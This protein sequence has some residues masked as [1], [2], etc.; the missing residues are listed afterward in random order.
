M[1]LPPP[2]IR[3]AVPSLVAAAPVPEPQ[4]KPVVAPVDPCLAA[5]A[6]GHSDEDEDV[7]VGDLTND[8]VAKEMGAFIESIMGQQTMLDLLRSCSWL[9]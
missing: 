3:A 7:V 6:A 5:V 1:D 4:E 8:N 9:W 2:P